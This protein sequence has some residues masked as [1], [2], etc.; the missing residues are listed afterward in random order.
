MVQRNANYSRCFHV[1]APSTTP[2]PCF[3]KG[4]HL[5]RALRG[6]CGCWQQR[7]SRSALLAHQVA[8]SPSLSRWRWREEVHA[9]PYSL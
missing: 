3:R 8:A 7:Y 2:V 1:A 6:S 5:Q 9:L 4:G